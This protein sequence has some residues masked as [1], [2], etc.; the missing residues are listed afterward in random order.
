M[1]SE[2]ELQRVRDHLKS[3]R[4]KDGKYKTAEPAKNDVDDIWILDKTVDGITH[5]VPHPALDQKIRDVVRRKEEAMFGVIPSGASSDKPATGSG[6]SQEA[7]CTHNN[8]SG[9]NP[10]MKTMSSLMSRFFRQVNDAVIDLSTGTA[11]VGLKNGSGSVITLEKVSVPK[12]RRGKAAETTTEDSAEA[13]V[14]T[15]GFQLSENPFDAMS[16]SIPAYATHCRVADINL[17]DMVVTNDG[18]SGWC[19]AKPTKNSVRVITAAGRQQTI[20]PPK[21]A[22]LGQEPGL[23]VVRSM[24]GDT[25]DTGMQS[26]LPMLMMMREEGGMKDDSL[27]LMLAATM[28]TGQSGAMSAMLPMLMMSGGNS[29]DA[30]SKMAVFMMMAQGG[31]Q[32]GNAMMPFVM[33]KLMQD[34]KS[35]G[36]VF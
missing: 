7:R 18:K 29:D 21:V 1:L 33:M 24:F 8:S 13:P 19:I 25:Q 20:S 28:S 9:E 17:G 35:G 5:T 31:G 34:K 11:R 3:V 36:S 2:K 15:F 22:M 27:G 12:P 32:T 23:M 10:I 14:E 16:T 6:A 4:L 30:M 26:M